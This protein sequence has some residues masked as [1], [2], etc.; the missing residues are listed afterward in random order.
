MT[1]QPRLN[2]PPDGAWAGKGG[3]KGESLPQSQAPAPLLVCACLSASLSDL[4]VVTAA[5][6]AVGGSV[7]LSVSLC[8]EI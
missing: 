2:P 5:A 8:K 6:A 3:R 1:G 4:T 7:C